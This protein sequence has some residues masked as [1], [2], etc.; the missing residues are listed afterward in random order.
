MLTSR[1][2]L[3]L[4]FTTFGVLAFYTSSMAT[5]TRNFKHRYATKR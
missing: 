3:S 5:P 2:Q 4:D 1:K